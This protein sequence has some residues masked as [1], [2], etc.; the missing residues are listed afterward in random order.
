MAAHSAAASADANVRVPPERRAG[1]SHVQA[2]LSMACWLG[3]IA[4]VGMLVSGLVAV[5]VHS[6]GYLDLKRDQTPT[7]QEAG[8]PGD[9]DS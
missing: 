2:F 4:G 3:W 9:T 1:T 8:A 6:A 5:A 7:A